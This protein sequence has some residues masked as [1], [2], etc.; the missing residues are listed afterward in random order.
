MTTTTTIT[1]TYSNEASVR[2][3]RKKD[4]ELKVL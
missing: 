1:T 4:C 2:E 3:V